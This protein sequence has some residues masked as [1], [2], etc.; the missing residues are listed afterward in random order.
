MYQTNIPIINFYKVNLHVILQKWKHNTYIIHLPI[1]FEWVYKESCTSIFCISDTVV[2]FLWSNQS[3]AMICL[4][5]KIV[6]KSLLQ[7]SA[8]IHI[9]KTYIS[10]RTCPYFLGRGYIISPNCSSA[11]RY[12]V[13]LL[14]LRWKYCQLFFFK[15]R[16]TWIIK[17]KQLPTCSIFRQTY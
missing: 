10:F 16:Y 11:I 6:M 5:Q 1:R 3:V 9:L 12:K 2:L 17:F 13:C 15:F 7:I 4:R 8:G 14:A